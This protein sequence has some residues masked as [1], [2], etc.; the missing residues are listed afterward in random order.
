MN[1]LLKIKYELQK[2]IF[3]LKNYNKFE[4]ISVVQRAYRIKY[5]NE[6]APSRSVILNIVFVFEKTASVA[7]MPPKRKKQ[8]K[9]S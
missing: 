8:S 4:N 6:K 5:R 2:R 7:P 9:N 3:L 1:C